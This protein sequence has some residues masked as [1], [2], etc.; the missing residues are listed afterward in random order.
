MRIKRGV[1]RKAKHNK[2]IKQAKGY[3]GRRKSV[4]KLAKQAVL[5]AGQYAYRDNKNKKREFRALWITRINAALKGFDMSYSVFI[6]KLSIAKI[7]INRK[8]LADLAK[9][10]PAAFE[11]VVKKL[12]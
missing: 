11:A 2:I 3:I 8:I 5:K 12:K 9:N 6:N 1:V 7:E 4:F 10:E